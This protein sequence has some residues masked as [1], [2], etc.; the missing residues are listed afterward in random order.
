MTSFDTANLATLS[1]E[2]QHSKRY[3][4][5]IFKTKYKSRNFR[6][7]LICNEKSTFAARKMAFCSVIY[8]YI[9]TWKYIVIYILS[10]GWLRRPLCNLWFADDIDPLGGQRR[11]TVNVVEPYIPYLSEPSFFANTENALHRWDPFWRNCC[12]C[13]CPSLL[14]IWGSAD[15]CGRGRHR[16]IR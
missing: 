16:P 2:K 9:G 5:P 12:I 14:P 15:T 1:F 3:R 4:Q 6:L 13:S 8:Q 11:R 10:C 7:D